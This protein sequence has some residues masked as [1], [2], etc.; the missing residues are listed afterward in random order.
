[1][2]GLLG[3]LS[4]LERL[5]FKSF[6]P[7]EWKAQ[8]LAVSQREDGNYT[9]LFDGAVLDEAECQAAVDS[10]IKVVLLPENHTI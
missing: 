9:E 10:G 8:L 5:A 4:K 3:R 2:T 7:P 6:S 1:M